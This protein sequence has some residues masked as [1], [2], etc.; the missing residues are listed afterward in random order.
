[1]SGCVEEIDF[2]VDYE[3]KKYS[4]SKQP[5]FFSRFNYKYFFSWKHYLESDNN[6]F[7][8]FCRAEPDSNPA[9]PFSDFPGGSLLK[10]I[11]FEK[12]SDVGAHVHMTP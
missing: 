3:S 12:K 4:P 2:G 1:M 9:Q 5:G 8:G 11:L 10:H 6:L 7:G